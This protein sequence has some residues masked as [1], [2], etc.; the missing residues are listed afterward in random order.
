M[1]RNAAVILALTVGLVAT[2]TAVA[3]EP[4]DV[5]LGQ[6]SL[7]EL[8]DVEVFAAS[9]RATNASDTPAAI[10][11]LTREDL[12]RH[13]V[14]HLVEAL[15]W[16]PGVQFSRLNAANTAVGVRGFTGVLSD[17]LL[18][19]IDGRSIYSLFYS[20]VYWDEHDLPIEDIE[21]IEIVRG[22]GG[23][24]WGANAV[25]GVINVVTRHSQDTLGVHASTHV[26]ADETSVKARVG[27]E[28]GR[29][30]TG[31]VWMI[32]RDRDALDVAPGDFDG[33]DWQNLSIGARV[34]VDRV[35]GGQLLLELDATGI[36]TEREDYVYDPATRTNAVVAPRAHT[37]RSGALLARWERPLG[38]RDAI[39]VQ[40]WIA[41]HDRDERI[42]RE[43]RTSFDV[44]MQYTHAGDR[45]TVVSGSNLRVSRDRLGGIPGY[46]F[47]PDRRTL[48]WASAFVQDEIRVGDRLRLTGGVKLEHDGISG[49]QWQPNLRSAFDTGRFGLFWGAVSRAVHTP[50]RALTSITMDRALPG[51]EI[52]GLP[53]VVDIEGADTLDA[54]S[55]TAFE[56]GWRHLFGSTTSVDVSAF[57]QDYDDLSYLR[58]GMPTLQDP[59]TATPWFSAPSPVAS[60]AEMTAR[61]FETAVMVRPHES[62]EFLAS[63]SFIDLELRDAPYD[64]ESGEI[65]AALLNNNPE[66]A[67]RHTGFL[68]VRTRPAPGWDLDTGIRLAAALQDVPDD[69]AIRRPSVDT[70]RE[71][72]A[73]IAWRPH[74][75]TEVALVGRN[76]FDDG[77]VDFYDRTR[78]Y[79]AAEVPTRV[80][81]QV[82]VAR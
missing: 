79:P 47:A 78:I 48:N 4:A 33:G 40:S 49:W 26:G 41:L 59:T 53:V 58:L 76:L 67:P 74:A 14:T 44:D 38:P 69:A 13:G 16:V 34:D 43:E 23:T 5:D 15:E 10:T 61:G 62:L 36:D 28:F 29:R 70:V 71:V 2:G 22:P 68:R 12:R 45:H 39:R 37:T 32:A 7:E 31:R 46:G 63:Y 21:R 20:G 35:A 51:V 3:D 60:G 55:V 19:L 25:N 24:L 75:A 8:L 42:F 64:P 27:R 30:A 80:F 72:F 81:L 18:V 17:K 66:D 65:A 82:Q 52:Q 50:S 57:Q 9:R 6:L 77:R 11:V 73:R 1:F 56:L 54:E